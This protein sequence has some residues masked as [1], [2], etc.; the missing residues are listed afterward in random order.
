MKIK[1]A[2]VDRKAV[3]AALDE[4]TSIEG[5]EGLA[6]D[7]NLLELG[8]IDSTQFMDLVSI[9]EDWTGV[10]IDFLEHDP[11]EMTSLDGLIATFHAQ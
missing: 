1:A 4:M 9:L 8:H 5:L 3:M 2:E 11:A 6:G 10:E 7:A